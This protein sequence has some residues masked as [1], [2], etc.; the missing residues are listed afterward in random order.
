MQCTV[1]ESKHVR[2]YDNPVLPRPTKVSKADPSTLV[3]DRP[4]LLRASGILQP[5]LKVDPLPAIAKEKYGVTADNAGFRRS[6]KTGH[7]SD[8]PINYSDAQSILD[9][10]ND[11]AKGKDDHLKKFCSKAFNASDF[12]GWNNSLESSDPILEHYYRTFEAATC[13]KGGKIS[14]AAAQRA[15]EQEEV[16]MSFNAAVSAFSPGQGNES[17]LTQ[18]MVVALANNA[19]DSSSPNPAALSFIDQELFW[20][21]SN[22]GQATNANDPLRAVAL[23]EQHPQVMQQS[24]PYTVPWSNLFPLEARQAWQ[25]LLANANAKTS[26]WPDI[27]TLTSFAMRYIS[28]PADTVAKRAARAQFA[29]RDGKP[30]SFTYGDPTYSLSLY[31]AIGDQKWYQKTAD[32]LGV[33]DITTL[34]VALSL[35][36]VAWGVMDLYAKTTGK[37]TISAVAL[38]NEA[39]PPGWTPNGF[40]D[41][42]RNPLKDCH[43]TG[44]GTASRN[45]FTCKY[46]DLDP[47][48]PGAPCPDG[49]PPPCKT[50]PP[51]HW[52]EWIPYAVGGSILIGGFAAYHY[53][54]ISL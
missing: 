40:I 7:P 39:P 1:R 6:F 24:Y 49:K 37:T 43:G 28:A 42:T 25:L 17:E 44:K 33:A 9:A 50:P 48:L 45:P 14:N 2:V 26:G 34:A 13:P 52:P 47:L 11:W 46:P 23:I 53:G 41:N 5:A 8:K 16:L 31:D 10:Y 27:E 3:T 22:V 4:W 36:N 20:M 29:R 32:Y 51:D 15:A 12:K 21:Q 18:T 19:H 38:K 35:I 54:F 30:P